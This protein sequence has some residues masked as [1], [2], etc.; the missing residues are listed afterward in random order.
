MAPFSAKSLYP[1]VIFFT[2]LIAVAFAMPSADASPLN[3][4]ASVY[5]V[6]KLIDHEGNLQYVVVESDVV[7]YLKQEV[8]QNYKSAKKA[9]TAE[10]NAWNTKH[11]KEVPFL[12]PAPLKP[13]FKEMAKKIESKT[14]ASIERDAIK[15]KGPFCVVQITRGDKK[16]MPEVLHKD[17]VKL[18]QF[19][20]DME[21]YEQVQ[22]W[23]EE[24]VAFEKDNPGE[25]YAEAQPEKIQLKV[26]KNSIKTM[27]KANAFI[28]KKVR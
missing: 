17:E 6:V 1:T 23:A 14:A 26:L 4:T 16:E 9:W 21:Y 20:L 22:I 10:K 28:A 12:R 13:Y 8:D 3:D 15:S 11:G 7:K 5:S 19:A 25:A 2:A 27:E 18:R 24:K